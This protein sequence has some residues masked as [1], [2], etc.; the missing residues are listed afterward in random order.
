MAE[1]NGSAEGRLRVPMTHRRS[2]I[3]GFVHD[4]HLHAFPDSA[5]ADA[6]EDMAGA[7][8]ARFVCEGT[9]RLR[10]SC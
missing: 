6:A 9:G 7:L 10:A 3:A 5:R 4:R 1:G 8:S 2:F